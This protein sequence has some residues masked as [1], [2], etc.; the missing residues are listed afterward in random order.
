MKKI[1]VLVDLV[2][3]NK[4]KLV[5]FLNKHSEEKYKAYLHPFSDLLF[6]IRSG[7]VKIKVKDTDISQFDLVFVRRAGK[8]VRFMGAISKYLDYKKIKFVDPCFREIGMSMDK[9]SSAIRL[10]IKKIPMPDTY[11]CFKDSVIKNREKIIKNLGFPIIAKAIL[12]QRNQNIFILKSPE[13]FDEL[14]KRSK[15]EFIFQKFIDIELEY[16]FLILGEKVRVLEQKFKRNYKKI[17]VEY[18]DLTG[19]SVFLN[20][21][22]TSDLANK[23]SL[24]AAKTLGLDIAGVDLAIEKETGRNYII[25]VNKGPGIEPD[26]RTSPELKAFSDYLISRVV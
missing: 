2:G 9:A 19:P 12:S 16:R 23:I 11:F 8:Y 24:K 26:A 7:K 1:L 14:L 4:K 20:L 3:L 18:Q 25:E 6:E 10:A 15:K 5:R 22:S 21:N 13:D 17:K